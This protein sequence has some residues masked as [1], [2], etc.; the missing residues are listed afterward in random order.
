MRIFANVC[1]RGTNYFGWQRQPNVIT[2]QEVI[3]DKLSQFFNRQITIYG[4]GRTDAGVHAFGQKFHFDVEVE[5]LDLDRLLYSIN[6]MLPNDIKIDDLE[7]VEDDFHARYSAKAKIYVYTIV[8]DS[9]DPFLYDTTFLHPEKID[10][11]LLKEV[12]THF[13]GVHNFKNFT[14]KE[15]DED[16]FVREI[17]NIEVNDHNS[18][19]NIT[20]RGDGFM[21][22]MIR[23]IIGTALRV[24]DK[25]LDIS[26]IDELLS[27]DSPR[28]IVSYKAP[29]CGLALLE[30]EY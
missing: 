5:E 3:E 6:M 25:K 23:F 22:Y 19:I 28:N 14:S 10:V 24:V 7:E 8:Q 26:K 27:D 18:I 2:V 21:R 4:A 16:N 11:D 13:I 1:Y 9:K 12:L 15:E 20:L 30:V 17:Y 29:A